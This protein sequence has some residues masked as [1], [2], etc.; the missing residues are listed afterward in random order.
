MLREESEGY[1]KLISELLAVRSATTTDEALLTVERLIG[2]WFEM[3][4]SLIPPFF[5]PIQFGPESS[6]RRDIGL[7]REQFAL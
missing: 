4:L 7:L 5:R 6:A 2:E 3:L 1:A